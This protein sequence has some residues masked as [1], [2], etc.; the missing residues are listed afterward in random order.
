MYRVSVCVLGEVV[1]CNPPA[2]LGIED[3]PADGFVSQWREYEKGACK[4]VRP[5]PNHKNFLVA[6]SK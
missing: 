5:V 3:T 4:E 2:E 6:A 1:V